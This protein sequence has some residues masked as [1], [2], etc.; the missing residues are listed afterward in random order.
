M[1]TE[2]CATGEQPSAERLG[3]EVVA[4]QGCVEMIVGSDLKA[5]FRFYLD[6]ARDLDERRLRLAPCAFSGCTVHSIEVQMERILKYA[7]RG[8]RY[9]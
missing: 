2:S 3:G 5:S 6:A 8:F 4:A 1:P 9:M 7:G